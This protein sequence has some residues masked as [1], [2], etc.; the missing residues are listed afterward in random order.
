MKRKRFWQCIAL[1]I[2]IIMVGIT[3]PVKGSAQQ[4]QKVRVG[5]VPGDDFL[6]LVQEENGEGS[7]IGYMGEFLEVLALYGNWDYEF[8]KGSWEDC[9]KWLAEGKI[10]L[11]PEAMAEDA[12]EGVVLSRLP[13]AS[14]WERIYVP[15]DSE[16]TFGSYEVLQDAKI[17]YIRGGYQNESFFEEHGLHCELVPYDS[18][19]A[20]EFALRSRNVDAFMGI[21]ESDSRI[22]NILLAQLEP[23]SLYLGMNS[24]NPELLEQME[25]AYEQL[26]R[27]MPNLIYDLKEKY[28]REE[29]NKGM[30]FSNM[31]K[32]WIEEHKVVSVAFVDSKRPNE[33]LDEDGNPKGVNV[34]FVKEI[35]KTVGLEPNWIS[36]SSTK[37]ALSY[38]ESGLVDAVTTMTYNSGTIQDERM[39][40]TSPYREFYFAVLGKKNVDLHNVERPPVFVV[41]DGDFVS[42]DFIRTTYPNSEIIYRDAE[43]EVFQALKNGTAKA[44][45]VMANREEYFRLKYDMSLENLTPQYQG[46]PIAMAVKQDGSGQILATILNQGIRHLDSSVS[47]SIVVKNNDVTQDYTFGMYLKKYSMIIIAVVL[48]LVLIGGLLF[49]LHRRRQQTLLWKAAYVDKVTGRYN[50]E[51]MVLD[52]EHLFDGTHQ[53]EYGICSLD[54]VNFKFVNENFGYSV[55]NHVLSLMARLIGEECKE[56]EYCARSGGDQFV[57]VLKSHETEELVGRM[58]RLTDKIAQEVQRLNGDYKIRVVAGVYMLQEDKDP[59]FAFD[60]ANLAR[61]SVRDSRS[62]NV[63]VY[64]TQMHRRTIQAREIEAIMYQSLADE[65]FQ[66]YLQPRVVIGTGEIVAAE[67][68]VR[69]QRKNGEMI[70]PD[71]FIPLFEANGFIREM[72]FFIYEK[73]C[74]MLKERLEKQLPIVPISVNVSRAHLEGGGF[75]PH[76]N[77]LIEE[78]QVPKDYVEMELTESL[79]VEDP[80]RMIAMVKEL[81]E[82]DYKVS[83]DDFGSGYSSLNILKQLHFDLLK[84]DKE[85]LR[86]EGVKPEDRIILQ[87]VIRMAKE[88]KMQVLIEGVETKEQQQ[89]LTQMDCD[90]AQGYYFS[91]PIPVT[92]FLAHLEKQKEAAK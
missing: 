68:L 56:A 19:D 60:K 73:V 84:I 72:D 63:A 9:K 11:F 79:L 40:T 16:V 28:V 33:Y 10:D 17:G 50:Y 87:N 47:N 29:D 75:L 90:F 32:T 42:E 46:L 27:E 2:M 34:D 70:Y 59:H 36:V 5:Y 20:L 14:V 30:V 48:G 54:V 53:G 62:R 65:E 80:D 26:M 31:E 21:W 3:W 55:G 69:W 78:Y 8:V 85:F 25:E 41:K 51:K 66:V 58:K 44:T 6:T 49:Y 89:M 24:R 74:R 76:F 92:D 86:T 61:K 22:G 35:L 83:I 39:F 52:V 43:E 37:Q 82:N 7:H 38:L 18:M 4:K 13:I 88:L 15:A 64:D 81:K 12:G 67:A 91:R 1:C 45:V 71:A 77:E 23:R 57:L